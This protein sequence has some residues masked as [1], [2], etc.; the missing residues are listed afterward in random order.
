MDGTGSGFVNR[1]RIDYTYDPVTNDKLSRHEYAGNVNTW[2]LIKEEIWTYTS[3]NEPLSYTRRSDDGGGF[4]ENDERKLYSYAG[5]LE[6]IIFQQ[7]SGSSWLNT[8]MHSYGYRSGNIR[9]SLFISN[10]DVLQSVWTDSLAL[11]FDSLS[12]NIA[13][14]Y[15]TEY[16]SLGNVVQEAQV[17]FNALS[18]VVYE[19]YS[20]GYN[21]LSR[22]TYELVG[23][24]FLKPEESYINDFG[25]INYSTSSY[26]QNG[27]FIGSNGG[28]HCFMPRSNSSSKSYSSNYNPLTYSFSS[29]SNVSDSYRDSTFYYSGN[30]I[31]QFTYIP[32]ENFGKKICQGDTIRP[33]LIISGG[34]GPYRFQW[35]PSVGLSSDTVAE[36][37]IIV[38]DTI[39]YTIIVTDSLGQSGTTSLFVRPDRIVDI[40]YDTTLCLSCPVVLY[41]NKFNSE[42]CQW[43]RD[44][45]AIPGATSDSLYVDSSGLYYAILSGLSY[46]CGTQ[47]K[48]VQINLFDQTRIT[49]QVYLDKDSNCV[50]D[51]TDSPLSMFGGS[52][53]FIKL[54][55]AG[56]TLHVIP[57]SAGFFD[58]PVDTGTYQL[59]VMSPTP[60]F[61][62]ACPISGILSV[63][64]SNYN[65]TITDNDFALRPLSNCG[66]LNVSVNAGIFRACRTT[67][68]IVHY[69]NSGIN[70]QTDPVVELFLPQELTILS[71]QLSYTSLPGNIYQ[72]VLPTLHV[73]Q[74][75]SF[76]I[77]AQVLC[78][79]V[80]LNNAT[81][82]LDA[83]I[84][85]IDFCSLQPDSTWSGGCV[86]V[87]AYCSSDSSVCFIISNDSISLLGEMVNFSQWRLYADNIL[88]QQGTFRLNANAD[89]TLCFVSDGRTFR[90]EA[91]QEAGFPVNSSP[92]ASI[93]RC[94]ILQPG[95]SFSLNKIL[96]VPLDNS[97][98]FHYTYCAQVLNSFDPNEKI[99]NPQ[100]WG[101]DHFTSNDARLNYRINFQNVGNDTA[102][103]VQVIDT[104]DL[105]VLDISTLNLLGSD[106]SYLFQLT[107]QNILNWTFLE[108][109]LPDSTTNEQAS[110]GFVEFS[111]KTKAALPNGTIIKNTGHAIFDFNPTVSTAEVINTIC[112]TLQP[113]ISVIPLSAL[114]QAD[115][116]AFSV[117][118]INGGSTPVYDW[119]VNNVLSYSG[120][121]VYITGLSDQDSIYCVM[122]SSYLCALPSVVNSNVIVYSLPAVPLITYVHPQL[123]SSAGLAYQW[124]FLQQAIPGETAQFLDPV[125]D[126]E[127]VVE[128]LDSNGCWVF[129]EPFYYV[130]TRLDFPKPTSLSIFPNPAFDFISLSGFK[131]HSEI[132]IID[133]A[134]KLVKQC[135]VVNDKEG[136][137]R[138]IISD[139]K[140][141][142]YF[143]S[144]LSGTYYFNKLLI[145]DK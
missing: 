137:F 63:T 133:V 80:G 30:Y 114:C 103:M 50:F 1:T 21:N 97:L 32:F 29:Y 58:V 84:K 11:R 41:V 129:S 117:A 131:D 104:L 87:G 5:V 139:L 73:G 140:P 60:V 42:S 115:T 119:Y 72:F 85:P 106:H 35:T 145:A 62:S 79:P 83:R 52:P 6:S 92:G 9:D 113:E 27:V 14:Y 94:G 34:C 8:K 142:M 127:Y 31:N 126:G 51:L 107:D 55:K 96:Q 112:E 141:G 4:L 26:D 76:T 36:P 59:S 67:E 75:G 77:V 98:P 102:F 33:G 43:F 17:R 88:I 116:V 122:S 25:C 10:W 120:D 71:S 121:T 45:V 48:G 12:S 61:T 47:T 90:L 23:N 132:S 105:S 65:D 57:D 68:I 91:D 15:S 78:D 24:N 46:V 40:S 3:G 53:F 143:I 124:Y 39:T 66:S 54:E 13:I 135:S 110:H 95:Q 22:H 44:S 16:D 2:T 49:G 81:L 89:T 101:N 108:I 37:Q 111:I 144:S 100:G 136:I 123:V 19:S 20:S 7:G 38:L 130:H 93:E 28:S 18:D 82:C 109:N 128:V 64:V 74:S 69:F 138:I 134:G 118:S 125:N 70:V 86:R 56:Y 99:V